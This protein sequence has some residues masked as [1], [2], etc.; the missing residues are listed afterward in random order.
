[1]R[2]SPLRWLIRTLDQVS[3]DLTWAFA[4]EDLDH[5]LVARKCIFVIPKQGRGLRFQSLS[6]GKL[7]PLVDLLKTHD[8]KI[9]HAT[10]RL[11]QG[12][13]ALR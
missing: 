8:V 4:W 12:I 10:T 7:R 11:D 1:V 3:Y 6:A 5:V 9:V 13:H 2:F